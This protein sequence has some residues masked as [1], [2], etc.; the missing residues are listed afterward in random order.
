MKLEIVDLVHMDQDGFSLETSV[1]IEGKDFI[2]TLN[3]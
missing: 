3:L 2:H 1:Y